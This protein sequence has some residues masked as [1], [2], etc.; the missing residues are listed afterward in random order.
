[1]W[2][3]VA[4]VVLFVGVHS[5]GVVGLRDRAVGLVGEGPWKGMYALVA[6]VGLVAMVYGYGVARTSPMVAWAPPT[7]TRHLA[8]LVMLPVFPLL[9]AAYLPGRIGRW[10]GHPMLL[11]TILWGAAHLLANGLLHDVVLFGSLSAWAA[12]TWVSFSWRSR[13][14]IP[15]APPTPYND[16][17]AVVVGLGVYGALL[18]GVHQWAFGVAPIRW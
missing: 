3:L 10:V 8:L 1:M 13:R 4:G 6:I 12:V 2:M 15:G 16:V 11:G 5:V 18:F 17:I 9:S 14:A 7:W